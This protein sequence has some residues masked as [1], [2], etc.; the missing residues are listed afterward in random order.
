MNRRTETWQNGC[1][2]L[3]DHPVHTTTNHHPP[4]ISVLS[5]TFLY[6]ILA[7]KWLVRHLSRFPKEQRRTLSSDSYWMVYTYLLE[8]KANVVIIAGS[9]ACGGGPRM[10]HFSII[11]LNFLTKSHYRAVWEHWADSRPNKKVAE[12]QIYSQT[13]SKL[14]YWAQNPLHCSKVW[15]IKNYWKSVLGHPISLDENDDICLSSMKI[16][17][18]R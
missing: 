1:F 18:L 17:T 7:A 14:S 2:R 11:F 12:E 9:L 13:F 8:D 10:V 16:F 3:D 4:K 15:N 6:I 5:K